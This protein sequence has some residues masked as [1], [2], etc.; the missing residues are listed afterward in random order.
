MRNCWEYFSLFFGCALC[1]GGVSGASPLFT[2]CKLKLCWGL[3]LLPD[4]L[5]QQFFDSRAKLIVCSTNVLPTVLKAAKNCPN[6]QKI[7]L[8][9]QGANAGEPPRSNGGP[10]IIM[11]NDLLKAQP[12]FTHVSKDVDLKNDVVLLPYSRFVLC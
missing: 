5:H 3:T 8:V 4:E 10:E 7:I 12:T 9:D 1:G 2:D 11:F 6:L